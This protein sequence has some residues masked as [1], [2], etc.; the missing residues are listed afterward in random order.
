VP[1]VYGLGYDRPLQLGPTAAAGAL[2][3]SCPRCR[4]TQ[5]EL[6]AAPSVLRTQADGALTVSVQAP[7]VALVAS[8]PS[9]L[10]TAAER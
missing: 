5:V 9:A 6:A 1:A 8:V 4:A 3:V 7:D 2:W 10:D